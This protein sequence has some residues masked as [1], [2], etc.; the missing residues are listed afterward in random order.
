M[1]SQNEIIGFRLNHNIAYQRKLW[2]FRFKYNPVFSAIGAG[3]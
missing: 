1:S 2:N 3:K